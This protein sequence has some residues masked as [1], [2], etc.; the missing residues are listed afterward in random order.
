ML[1]LPCVSFKVAFP[2]QTGEQAS[3]V[4]WGF[5]P[6]PPTKRCDRDRFSPL[7]SWGPNLPCAAWEVDGR[8]GDSLNGSATGAS[9]HSPLIS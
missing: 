3:G 4:P 8:A 5:D 6:Q 1:L 2:H 7:L 9:V